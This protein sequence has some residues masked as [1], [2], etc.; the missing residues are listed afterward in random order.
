[1]CGHVCLQPRWAQGCHHVRSNEGS[2]EKSL[3]PSQK[4]IL[5]TDSPSAQHP[6]PLHHNLKTKLLEFNTWGTD[7][8]IPWECFKDA[9][10]SA[11]SWEFSHSLSKTYSATSFQWFLSAVKAT[12][13]FVVNCFY[14]SIC[15]IR[16]FSFSKNETAFKE[17]LLVSNLNSYSV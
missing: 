11:C 1:M 5:H 12:E 6:H 15:Q 4:A 13:I 14:Y 9:A 7:K 2:Q 16:C 10:P 17:T 3:R 8:S